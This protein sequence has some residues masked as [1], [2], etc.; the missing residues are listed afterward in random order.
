[1]K[2]LSKDVENIIQSAKTVDEFWQLY[3]G[4]FGIAKAA[5]LY[6]FMARTL[7]HSIKE[8]VH[9]ADDCNFWEKKSSL[10]PEPFLS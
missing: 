2:N 4:K 9:H 7:Q 1:M 8:E 5:K 3:I 10:S 6:R